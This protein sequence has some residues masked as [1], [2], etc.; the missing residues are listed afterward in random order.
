M[1]CSDIKYYIPNQ[2]LN[3]RA[4]LDSTPTTAAL[5]C[6]G[7]SAPDLPAPDV[8]LRKPKQ[9]WPLPPRKHT[10]ASVRQT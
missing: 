10:F 6:P 8:L 5:G 9:D 2:D 7:E 4:G 1:N 3:S